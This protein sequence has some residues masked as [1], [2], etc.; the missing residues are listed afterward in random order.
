M[1]IDCKYVQKNLSA[2]LDEEISLFNQKRIQKHLIKCKKCRLKYK[3]LEVT[4]QTLNTFPDIS[5]SKDFTNK[6]MEQVTKEKNT[7][8][9]LEQWI[10]NI[11]KTYKLTTVTISLFSVLGISSLALI[12]NKLPFFT[13]GKIFYHLFNSSYFVSDKLVQVYPQLMI[14]LQSTLLISLFG[15]VFMFQQFNKKNKSK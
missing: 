2:Y 5:P 7:N 9:S 15:F 6:V 10:S 8:L 12:A 13:I 4:V 14:Y 11:F 1:N 3:N